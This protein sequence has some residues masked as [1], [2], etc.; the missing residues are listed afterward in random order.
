MQITGSSTAPKFRKLA[1]STAAAMSTARLGTD[2]SRSMPSISESALRYAPPRMFP[3]SRM[4]DR[5]ISPNP[6]GNGT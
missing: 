1:V 4:A 3:A 2:V 6:S 5:S